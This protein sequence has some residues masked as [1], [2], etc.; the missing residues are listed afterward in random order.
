MNLNVVFNYTAEQH[1]EFLD[2]LQKV[3]DDHYGEGVQTIEHLPGFSAHAGEELANSGYTALD[4]GDAGH[5]DVSLNDVTVLDIEKAR[6]PGPGKNRR[7]KPTRR[8]PASG[9]GKY[10]DGRRPGKQ[11]HIAKR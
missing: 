3:L 11:V 8:S 2:R 1:Q 10:P 5:I 6:R 4:L 9:G 7:T